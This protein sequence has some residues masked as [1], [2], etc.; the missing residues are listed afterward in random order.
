MADALFYTPTQIKADTTVSKN[1]DD[2]YLNEAILAMQDINI[3][4]KLGTTLYDELKAEVIADTLAGVNKTLMDSYIRPALKWYVRAE[5]Q[6]EVA[7]K[8]MNKGVVSQDGEHSNP[9]SR[10][11]IDILAERDINK[12]EWYINQMINYLCEN[13]SSY[14]SY[15]N[16]DSGVDVIQPDTNSFTTSLYLGG[17]NGTQ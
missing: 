10:R 7:Y 12:A 13:S 11:D 2:Q 17:R 16:P 14:P 3:H 8:V 1:V 9:V 5:V 15:E 4:P 6:Y